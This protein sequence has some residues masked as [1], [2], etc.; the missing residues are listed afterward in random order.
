MA[1]VVRIDA[2]VPL[3]RITGRVFP[4]NAYLLATGKG[5]DCLLV[6][7]GLDGELIADAVARHGLVPRAVVCTHGH[8]DHIGSAAQFQKAYD[9]PVYLHDA[10]VPTSRSSN[11]LLMAMK[12]DRR[13]VVPEVERVGGDDCSLS[14]CGLDV[15]YRATPGHTP[16]SCVVT[17]GGLAFTGDTLYS[18]GVGLSGLPGENT[19]QLKG[20]LHR[21]L[22]ALPDDVLVL[23]GHGGEAPLCDIKA[24]NVALQRF[25]GPNVPVMEGG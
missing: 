14:L 21:L 11:F 3:I 2:P 12:I 24:S 1:D 7:P 25:L 8:F 17:I 13:I 5:N 16:G 4:S 23:P 10:D 18:R 22:T 20:T 6:D 15:R 19:E 9:I